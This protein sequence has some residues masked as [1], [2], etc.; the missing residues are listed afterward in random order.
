MFPHFAVV[1]DNL[2][3]NSTLYVG[4]V[5]CHD[6]SLACL[7]ICSLKESKKKIGKVRHSA[8]AG[9]ND[10]LPHLKHCR[11]NKTWRKSF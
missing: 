3:S 5:H 11:T 7:Y 9:D 10:C 1:L 8:A 2:Y 4:N 6:Y